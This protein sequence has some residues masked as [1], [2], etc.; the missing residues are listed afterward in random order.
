[1]WSNKRSNE[2]KLKREF[3]EKNQNDNEEEI[4][5]CR[6]KWG[7]GKVL[8]G[9]AALLVERLERHLSPTREPKRNVCRRRG[10]VGERFRQSSI[11]IHGGQ[12][13]PS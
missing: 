8:K 2:K 4:S 10:G 12:S 3:K 9:G 11:R 5:K 13:K 7:G 6:N 1:L